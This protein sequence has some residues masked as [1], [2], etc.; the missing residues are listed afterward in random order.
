MPRGVTVYGLAVL[1]GRARKS[2]NKFFLNEHALLTLQPF[3]G[4]VR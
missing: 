1:W 3:R 4:Q 2:G